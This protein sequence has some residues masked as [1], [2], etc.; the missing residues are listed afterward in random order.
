MLSANVG[1]LP[2]GSEVFAVGHVGAGLC[3]ADGPGGLDALH[4]PGGVG[5]SARADGATYDAV[6]PH[7]RVEGVAARVVGFRIF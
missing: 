4:A 3:A 7:V 6:P 5:I 2:L 1:S